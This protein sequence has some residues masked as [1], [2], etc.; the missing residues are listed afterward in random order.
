MNDVSGEANNSIYSWG[1]WC[2]SPRGRR[3]ETMCV[4]LHLFYGENDIYD[5]TKSI[6]EN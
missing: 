6:V 2:S 3:E 4:H 1:S 5:I